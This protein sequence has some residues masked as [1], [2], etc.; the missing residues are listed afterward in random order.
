[1]ENAA[2]CRAIVSLGLGGLCDSSPM[3]NVSGC[4]ATGGEGS[5]SRSVPQK[6]RF[7]KTFTGEAFQPLTS[8]HV[9]LPPPPDAGLG[10]GDQNEAGVEVDA[11]TRPKN[12]KLVFII[13]IE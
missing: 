6:I 3:Y 5:H 10:G 1:M 9:H 13:R 11:E 7:Q 12:M 4:R 2:R 8:G